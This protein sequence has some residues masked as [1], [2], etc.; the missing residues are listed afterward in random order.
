MSRGFGPFGK[1]QEAIKQAQQVRDNAQKLQEELENLQIIGQAGEGRVQVTLNGNQEPIAVKLDPSVL[2]EA[3]EVVENLLL[4]A[5]KAA[6]EESSET[7]R[8]RM[9]ELTSGFNLSGLGL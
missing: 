4:T 7:M 3:P 2:Q 5:F 1:I 9:E 8:K 6:Y